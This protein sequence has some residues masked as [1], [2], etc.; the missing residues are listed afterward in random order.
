ML[1]ID[2]ITDESALI[3]IAKNDYEPL[4]RMET[5]DKI[6]DESALRD[7]AE[8][9]DNDKVKVVAKERIKCISNLNED[10]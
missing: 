3:D 1:A 2:K 5:I 9:D 6:T 4:I 7:I 8:N 10:T